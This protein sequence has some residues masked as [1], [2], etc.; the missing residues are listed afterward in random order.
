MDNPNTKRLGALPNANG[1]LTR[2]AYAQA[3]AG[4][5]DPQ[6]LL[7]RANLTVHQ[8][9]DPSLR[10][11][12][13]DQIEFLNLVATALQDDV[14]GFHLALPPDLR[15]LGFLF[16]VLASSEILSDAL[17]RVARYSTITNEGV[18]LKYIDE[19]N[20][21]I[22]F[23]YVGIGRHLDRHQIEFFM[24]LLVRLCRQLT[25]F[26]LVPNRVRLAHQRDSKSSELNE[27]FGRTIEFGAAIDEVSFAPTIKNM[28]IVSADHY[29]NKLLVM[30][31]EEALS[32]RRNTRSSFRSDVENAIVPLL[33]HGKARLD[34]V[35]RLLGV[36]QRTFTRRL[37]SENQ[38]FSGVLESL[39]INLAECYLADRGL[40]ISQIGWLLGYQE[41]SS[42]T[43]AFKRWTGKTPRQARP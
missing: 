35:A 24:T 42:F 9:E 29:L 31:C 33:P 34:E 22:T 25:G 36:S 19:T 27:F 13:R 15:E 43:H 11:S 21:S 38:T 1:T 2:L 4:G 41:V 30:Y 37:S 32:R 40:S 7:K 6:P 12:V 18:S 10:L 14:L 8:I 20:I 39:K 17:R 5:V 23:R 3:R 16:Y 28:P 26:R